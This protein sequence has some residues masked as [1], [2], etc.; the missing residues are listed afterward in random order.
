M[1]H[2]DSGS[3]HHIE[4]IGEE[5]AEFILAFRTSAQRISGSA[6]RSAR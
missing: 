6:P 2:V 3:L 5:P 4:N 1:F